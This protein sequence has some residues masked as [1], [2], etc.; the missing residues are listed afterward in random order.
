[1]RDSGAIRRRHQ[2]GSAR[3][4]IFNLGAEIG[5]R[6]FGK[7]AEVGVGTMADA[8]LR[9]ALLQARQEFV[10][11]GSFNVNTFD[12]DTYAS[13]IGKGAIGDSFDRTLKVAVGKDEARVLPPELKNRWDK[14]LRG[15]FCDL[16]AVT[17]AAGEEYKVRAGF[18]EGR[19]LFGIV[20]QHLHQIARQACLRA[21]RRDEIS[22]FGV[23]SEHLSTTALPAMSAVMSG[24]TE[25]CK[26]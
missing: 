11:N 1:M 3:K 12:R 19:R 10:V 9:N 24:I 13:G 21:D 18:D 17:A 7:R 16:L 15:V 25:S 20:V 4:R 22:R 23:R 6:I 2:R 8:N 5:L 26:G 14:V